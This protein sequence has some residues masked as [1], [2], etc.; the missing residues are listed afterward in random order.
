VIYGLAVIVLFGIVL[1]VVGVRGRRVGDDPHCAACGFNLRGLEVGTNRCPECGGETSAPEAVRRGVKRRRR[2]PLVAG[3][4]L[5]LAAG[6][7]LGLLGWRA[8]REFDWTPYEP[9]S[10]LIADVDGAGPTAPAARMQ[11]LIR[12]GSDRSS[13]KDVDRIVDAALA[14]QADRSKPW[15]AT[16]AD[17]I[18]EAAE[19]KRLDDE[20]FKRC[21]TQGISQTLVTR[22]QLRDGQFVHAQIDLRADHFIPQTIL[23]G[24]MRCDELRIGDVSVLPASPQSL[25]QPW[26]GASTIDLRFPLTQELMRKLPYT[27]HTMATRMH[28][29]FK[30]IDP[31]ISKEMAFELP[32]SAPVE[33]LPAGAKTDAFQAPAS[34]H[35]AMPNALRTN[36]YISPEGR[37]CVYVRAASNLPHALA[38]RVVVAQ[39]PV[40]YPAGLLF[41]RAGQPAAWHPTG[42][43]A[44]PAGATVPKGIVEVRLIPDQAAADEQLF[45]GSYWGE[46]MVLPSYTQRAAEDEPM[47]Y[48]DEHVSVARVYETVG[49]PQVRRVVRTGRRVDISLFAIPRPVH[50]AHRVFLSVAGQELELPEPWLAPNQLNSVYGASAEIDPLIT[51][52]DIILRPDAD[53]MSRSAD[54]LRP[55]AGEVLLRRVPITDPPP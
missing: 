44:P 7:P 48:S 28:F 37:I 10:W 1:L 53:W 47:F 20:R 19:L 42:W 50:F 5:F 17:V 21:L 6:V 18:H 2:T 3:L 54:P 22:P 25:D 41:V 30:V 39:G 31:F 14:R 27:K 32:V 16:W 46:L 9:T 40:E 38:M 24:R 13:Q 36:V 33:M 52:V 12:V 51:N 26:I 55:W 4:L 45:P 15:N 34:D 29:E 43:H 49:T 8:G 35:R 11:L 23:Q